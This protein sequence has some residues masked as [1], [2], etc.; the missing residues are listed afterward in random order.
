MY[1]FF[2]LPLL[3][4]CGRYQFG[5]LACHIR[6]C[7]PRRDDVGRKRALLL[8]PISEVVRRNKSFRTKIKY[9]KY[10]V[11]KKKE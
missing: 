10:F 6:L 4:L 1:V 2:G 7:V 5:A 9:M 3:S 11:F 8:V